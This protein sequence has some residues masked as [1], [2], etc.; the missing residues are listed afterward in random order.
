MVAPRHK[1]ASPSRFQRSTLAAYSTAILIGGGAL[2]LFQWAQTNTDDVI[3]SPRPPKPKPPVPPPT[4]TAAASPDKDAYSLAKEQSFGY[5]TDITN[6]NW[7]IAQTHHAR[8]F[9][10]YYANLNKFSNGPNDK[11]RAE[12]LRNSNNHYWY[13]QNFQTEFIC[14][15]ARRLPSD[16][17]ADGP[18]WVCDPHRLA[19]KKDCLVYSIGSNGKNEFEKAVKEE[20]GE[21][22][23]I[24]TFDLESYN[25]RNGHFK[26]ALKGYSE[27]HNYGLG[28]EG[29]A[30]RKPDVFKTLKQTMEELGHAGRTIDIFKIDCE[31]CEWFVWQDWLA[32][33]IDMRQILVETH[34]APMPN[35]RD[36]FFGLHDAGFVVFSKEANYE[37][38]AG[39]VE[40]GFVK[41]STDFFIEDSMYYKAK[42]LP[43]IEKYEPVVP[44][45]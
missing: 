40:Y 25:R 29:E 27:F 19:K 9:P 32:P 4:A 22:C 45:A 20:I 24:H 16:S 21:H 43:G 41:L 35:A 44:P 2:T 3:N 5:F 23:E 12:K 39:G 38:G 6:E 33:D 15:L 14:P 34:N 1:K 11:G 30:S 10:N 28:T 18:K 7:R 37:N 36:F 17:M 8:L 42:E 13:G 26:D 31:W